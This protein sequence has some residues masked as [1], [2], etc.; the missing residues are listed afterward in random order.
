MSTALS[1][2]ERLAPRRIVR[3]LGDRLPLWGRIKG[4]LLGGGLALAA[5]GFAASMCSVV[6]AWRDNRTIAALVAGADLPV[7]PGA[8]SETLLARAH[9]LLQRG[10]I[11]EA[12]AFVPA[13]EARGDAQL[14]ARLQYGLANARLRAAFSLLEQNRIDPAIPLV[15]LAKDGYRAALAIE[16]ANWD[17]RYNLDVAMRL[18]RDFPQIER[19]F[20]EPPTQAPKQLWTDLPGVPK[21]LP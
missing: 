5:A 13:V 14:L 20:D 19:S 9:F 16:P 1:H 10:R 4:A 21:G 8:R 2:L 7:G 6:S 3:A 18:V 15:R 12:Q 11:D 17:A